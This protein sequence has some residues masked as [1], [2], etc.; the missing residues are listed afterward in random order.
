MNDLLTLVVEEGASDLHIQ[1]GQ[2]PTLRLHGEMIPVDGPNL[3]PDDSEALVMAITSEERLQEV[4][5]SGGCR[6]RFLIS[7]IKPAFV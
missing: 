1:V 7:W 5:S 2:S 6:L 4:K 3:S